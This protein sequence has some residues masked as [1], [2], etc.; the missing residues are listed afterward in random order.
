MGV[1]MFCSKCGSELSNEALFCPHCGTEVAPVSTPISEKE[2]QGGESG[3]GFHAAPVSQNEPGA[4][5][6]QKKGAVAAAVVAVVV[7]C[8]AIGIGVWWKIDQDAKTAAERAEWERTHATLVTRIRVEAPDFDDNS[9]GIPVQVVGTDLDGNEVDEIQFMRPGSTQ[10]AMLQG[11]YDLTFPGG[12]LTGGGQVAKSQGATAHV[13][14]F[15]EG[16]GSAGDAG[17]P[18][19]STTGSASAG[20]D[21]SAGSAGSSPSQSSGASAQGGS[22]PAATVEQPVVYVLIDP[23]DVTDE[24]IADV[25]T[26]VGQDPEDNGK[27]E[28]LRQNVTAKREEAIA[29][30]KRQ[31]EEAERARVEARKA[32]ITQ[33][34]ED[35]LYYLYD[36]T[37]SRGKSLRNSRPVTMGGFT[38][39]GSLQSGWPSTR[40]VSVNSIEAIDENTVAYSVTYDSK[41]M[42]NPWESGKQDSGT[43]AF[44]ENG[45]INQ[46]YPAGSPAGRLV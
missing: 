27:A 3:L 37:G 20:S 43:I 12:Y 6:P 36:S 44:G 30:K 19:G 8:A 38:N 24:D 11:S 29:E 31:E 45:L 15:V 26:W 1:V 18:S 17:N 2:D 23:L 16:E 14:V 25:V 34:A 21:A 22:E 46:W 35:F 41:M 33:T 10:V 9:T 40:M 7:V 42:T 28:Q 5:K 13:D 4:K 39:G 32:E